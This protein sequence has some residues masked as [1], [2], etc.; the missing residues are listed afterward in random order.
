MLAMLL[1]FLRSFCVYFRSRADLQAEI[2]ALRH[3]IVVLPGQTSKPKLKPYGSPK[4]HLGSKQLI[5]RG[6]DWRLV[7]PC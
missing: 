3:Q 7:S 6:D 2:L 5:L 1:S 4:P